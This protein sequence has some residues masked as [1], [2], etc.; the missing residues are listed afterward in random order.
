MQPGTM[1]GAYEIPSKPGAGGMGE[2]YRA[3]DTRLDRDVALKI[4]PK[5]SRAIRI[6]SP[7]LPAKR[8][9]SRP[10]TILTS[11]NCTAW[12]KPARSAHWSWSSSRARICR[13]SSPADRCRSTR[14]SDR[15]ADRRCARS[16]TRRRHHPSRSEARQHQGAAG[17]HGQGARLRP[18]QGVGAGHRCRGRSA[19][20]PD[21]HF[22][23]A[24]DACGDDPRH[25]RLHVAGTGAWQGPRSPHDV[26]AFGCVFR[27][28]DGR[29]RVQQKTLRKRWRR[30]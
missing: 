1:F 23:G 24:D 6:A 7:A 19:L 27:D 12:K 13:S 28:A 3:R 30:S 26:W 10:S 9:R 22:S 29:P 8:A 16:R 25:G 17:R 15:A 5:R 18:R 4:L 2:V 14:R 21:D 20:V 11:H